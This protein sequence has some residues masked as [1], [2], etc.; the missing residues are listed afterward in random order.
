VPAHS[1]FYRTAAATRE[2]AGD[3][4]RFEALIVQTPAR[5][6]GGEPERTGVISSSGSSLVLALAYAGAVWRAACLSRAAGATASD[7]PSAIHFPLF[8]RRSV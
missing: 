4:S 5:T 3:E 7:S 2:G 6:P 8:D 1:P